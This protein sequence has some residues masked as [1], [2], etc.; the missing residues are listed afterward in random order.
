M[1]IRTGKENMK[2]EQHIL[3]KSRVGSMAALNKRIR[4]GGAVQADQMYIALQGAATSGVE[5][6]VKKIF[7]EML[8]VDA[9]QDNSAFPDLESESHPSKWARISNTAKRSGLPSIKSENFESSSPRAEDAIAV[10]R[11]AYKHASNRL[12]DL[13]TNTIYECGAR[14]WSE[15]TPGFCQSSSG[16][17][18]EA[19]E[20]L[21]MGS[22]QTIGVFETRAGNVLQDAFKRQ[23]GGQES[24]TL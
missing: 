20:S 14:V 21:S 11:Q 6:L 16:K 8:I 13:L 12:K 17:S 5:A 2:N 7:E 10:E 23:I 24:A 15:Q 18:L 22:W 9:D 19:F 4:N 1:G 3:P